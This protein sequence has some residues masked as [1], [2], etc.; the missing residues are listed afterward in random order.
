MSNR[1][2][3]FKGNLKSL[4]LSFITYRLIASKCLQQTDEVCPAG[5]MF[6]VLSGECDNGGDTVTLRTCSLASDDSGANIL[7]DPLCHQPDLSQEQQ[8]RCQGKNWKH[9]DHF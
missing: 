1:H 5:L 6:N 9:S 7:V 8:E 3:A 4:S 2:N